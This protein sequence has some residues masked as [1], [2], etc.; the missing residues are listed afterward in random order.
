MLPKLG[1]RPVSLPTFSELQLVPTLPVVIED[2]R[3][4]RRCSFSQIL[5]VIGGLVLHVGHGIDD[6]GQARL[7]QPVDVGLPTS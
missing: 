2:W 4:K 6:N 1:V 7:K 5:Q 3:T